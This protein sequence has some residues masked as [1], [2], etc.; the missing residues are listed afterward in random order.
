M[1]ATAVSPMSPQTGHVPPLLAVSPTVT[2]SPL[3]WPHPSLNSH[4]RV[5]HVPPQ[6][7]HPLLGGSVPS[8]TTSLPPCLVP[9][10]AGHIPPTASP[11][12]PWSVPIP[13]PPVPHPRSRLHPR[14]HPRPC[15]PA[16]SP[17]PSQPRGRRCRRG[18]DAAAPAPR[19]SRTGRVRVAQGGCRGPGP[20]STRPDARTSARPGPGGSPR[21]RGRE[22]GVPRG[23]H[24]RAGQGAFV[25]GAGC[26]P[27][28]AAAQ[29]GDCDRRDGAGGGQSPPKAAGEAPRGSAGRAPPPPRAG[30]DVTQ[31]PA[32]GAGVCVCVSMAALSHPVRG[33]RRARTPPG[34]G[35]RERAVSAGT[36]RGLGPAARPPP[37]ATACAPPRP[38][39]SYFHRE[40]AIKRSQ[41]RRDAAPSPD[42]PGTGTAGPER[43]E[44]RPPANTGGGWGHPGR[45]QRCWRGVGWSGQDRLPRDP[46]GQAALRGD[47]GDSVPVAPRVP[48]EPETPRCGQRGLRAG[49]WPPGCT[50]PGGGDEGQGSPLP[51]RRR[52]EAAGRY[53]RGAPPAAPARRPL[54]AA[55]HRGPPARPPPPGIAPGSRPEAG[56]GTHTRTEPRPPAPGPAGGTK[57]GC[58]RGAVAAGGRIPAPNKGGSELGPG[59]G[60]GCAAGPILLPPTPAPGAR[61]GPPG[62]AGPPCAASPRRRRRHKVAE[63]VPRGRARPPGAAGSSPRR[64]PGHPDRSPTGDAGPT[65]A[66]SPRCFLLGLKTTPGSSRPF[67]E[68]PR[69]C[70]GGGAWGTQGWGVPSGVPPCPGCMLGASGG[71]SPAA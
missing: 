40:G 14:P 50:C 8:S 33:Q 53:Q 42:V 60:G 48:P 52:G 29:R 61:V 70:G 28:P 35:R 65:F 51:G 69:G 32:R 47:A 11:S 2:T 16:P 27:L 57:R 6:W 64:H 62:R 49:G 54:S 25:H 63:E 67:R 39:W 4:S 59:V 15:P 7:P 5:P 45:S 66:S 17:S 3:W 9:P 41:L 58:V 44:L 1:V 46:W 12:P 55:C 31:A 68:R 21:S 10:C 56:W 38:R 13:A 18:G 20:H 26:G 71:P 19:S 30:T 23:S 43:G 36:G 34:G 37:P 24:A 22:R